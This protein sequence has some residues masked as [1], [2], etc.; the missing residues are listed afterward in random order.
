MKPR[1]KQKHHK[2]RD[3][4]ISQ[5]PLTHL[6][7]KKTTLSR[8]MNRLKSTN[9]MIDSNNDMIMQKTMGTPSSTDR[10][11]RN[12]TFCRDVKMRYHPHVNDMTDE[13]YQK[14]Y[15][16]D[17]EYRQIHDNN[18]RLM[19]S[20]SSQEK[21]A[22]ANSRVPTMGMIGRSDGQQACNEDN[23]E[24]YRGIDTLSER[25]QK[26]RRRRKTIN[27]VLLAQNKIRQYI[28]SRVLRDVNISNEPIDFNSSYSHHDN[29]TDTSYAAYEWVSSEFIS[30]M[31]Q[32]AGTS[33]SQSMAYFVGLQDEKDSHA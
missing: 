27:T 31:Y 24:S 9:K 7:S 12:V 19:I 14:V 16:Q 17:H 18:V 25:R 20:K 22:A 28:V 10:K 33:K 1:N 3:F 21:A 30:T 5:F 23:D 2:T 26:I 11:N 6:Y 15:Y 8:K 29:A 32:D 13:E 4:T